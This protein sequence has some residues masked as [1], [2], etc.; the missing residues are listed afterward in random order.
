MHDRSDVEELVPDP[1]RHSDHQHR[2]QVDRRVAHVAERVEGGVQQGVLVEQV[3]VAVPHQPELREHE[4]RR[5]VVVGLPGQG[6]GVLGVDPRVA[7]Q[8]QRHR[9]GDA[10]QVVAVGR[11]EGQVG[12]GHALLV[13]SAPRVPR[14]VRARRQ[15][16]PRRRVR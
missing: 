12:R 1:E 3:L 2:A 9:G 4:H 8:H 10:H 15:R 7:Q 5:V 16:S 13:R 11:G 14:D 6:D